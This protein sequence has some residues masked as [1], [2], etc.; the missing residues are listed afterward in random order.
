MR[1]VFPQPTIETPLMASW[2]RKGRDIGTSP[3]ILS[4]HWARTSIRRRRE[5]ASK[6][7]RD[8]IV[9]LCAVQQCLRENEKD[10]ETEYN[11]LH[12]EHIDK[13]RK[14]AR[15][16]RKGNKSIYLSSALSQKPIVV[17]VHNCS[18]LCMNFMRGN[19]M[20]VCVNETGERE[21]MPSKRYGSKWI[22]ESCSLSILVNW[23]L[24][25]SFK[26]PPPAYHQEQSLL[27]KGRPVSSGF[28]HPYI[29]LH[30][31]FGQI[32]VVWRRQRE[33]RFLRKSI[34]FIGCNNVPACCSS[35]FRLRGLYKATLL[36]L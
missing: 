31:Y 34:G 28:I 14:G 3:S 30:V 11:A 25:S 8:G 19:K 27:R 6:C 24:Y 4:N 1:R 13:G 16:S 18:W 9:L 12:N 29:P 17:G 15:A 36:S 35:W 33:M 10:T 7:D 23:L 5:R 2:V 20:W 21:V 32:V 26:L 22:L